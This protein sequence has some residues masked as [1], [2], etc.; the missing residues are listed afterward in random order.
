M[1][2]TT[3]LPSERNSTN[4][5]KTLN[6]NACSA[7]MTQMKKDKEWLKEVDATALQSS[8]R[9]LDEAYQELLSQGQKRRS[10]RLS[11]IQEQARQPQ[12]LQEQNGWREYQTVRQA[13]PTSPNWGL[14][15][16]VSP[17][18]WKGASFPQPS[19]R[20]PAAS[21]SFPFSV[22]TWNGNPSTQLVRL[23]A[24]TSD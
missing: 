12:I 7:N 8:I 10:T 4:P 11:T 17:N 6:Y 1:C 22:Q 9:D 20:T 21:I 3:I 13:H 19:V 14:F 18:K 24:S 15:T 16:V 2:I 5:R 23:S